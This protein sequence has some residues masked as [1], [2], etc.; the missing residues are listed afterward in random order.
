[1]R[2]SSVEG[3]QE[4]VVEAGLVV[5]GVGARPNAELFAGQLEA[6][7]APWGGIKVWMGWV[8]QQGRGALPWVSIKMHTGQEEVRAADLAGCRYMGSIGGRACG[9]GR[10]GVE[11]QGPAE[12]VG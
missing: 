7:P 5:V 4:S 6:G 8:G 12:S 1:M 9:A 3:A 11:H 10:A 2:L